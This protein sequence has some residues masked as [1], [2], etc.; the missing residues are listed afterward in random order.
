[1]VLEDQSGGPEAA[2]SFLKSRGHEDATIRAISPNIEDVFI[3]L[4]QDGAS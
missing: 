1:M 3:A 2:L 4:N